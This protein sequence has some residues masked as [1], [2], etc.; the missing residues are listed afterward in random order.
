MK[1]KPVDKSKKSNIK[2]E[3]CDHFAGMGIS[4]CNLTGEKKYYYQR[5]KKF[6]W[7]KRLEYKEDAENDV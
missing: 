4:K 3:H 2:C 1:R 7:S 5:C 6:E